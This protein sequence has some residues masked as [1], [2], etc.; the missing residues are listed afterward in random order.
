MAQVTEIRRRR[1]MDHETN[2][3]RA[4]IRARL[5]SELD[6][7]TDELDTPV[8]EQGGHPRHEA[9]YRASVESRRTIQRRI[10]LLSQLIAG[11]PMV[12]PETISHD[13]AGYGSTVFLR[14]LDTGSELFYTLMAGELIDLDANQV[15]LASPI[16]QALQGCR[17]GDEPTVET[18]HGRRRFRVLAL[19]TLPRSLGM[20]A[21]MAPDAA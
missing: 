13:R 11:L 8:P 20:A 19:Q 5:G 14:N 16:G 10:R 9:A 4:E 15:S 3:W 7:L 21:P 17:E 12:D 18:P 1:G 6:H 2:G